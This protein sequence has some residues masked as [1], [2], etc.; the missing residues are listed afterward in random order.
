MPRTRWI[1]TDSVRGYWESLT[2]ADRLARAVP[3]R[4]LTT[5]QVADIVVRIAGD[6][7]L[8]GRVIVWWSEDDAPRLIEWGDRGYR[9]CGIYGP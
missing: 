5:G 2:A 3:S 4:L 9:N 7:S 1:G 6:G 8:A